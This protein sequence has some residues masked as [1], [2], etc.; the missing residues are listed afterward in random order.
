[1]RF[2][3]TTTALIALILMPV[4]SGCLYSRE[5]ARTQ[6]AVERENPTVSFDRK[7]TLSVG[8]TGIGLLSG[9]ASFTP[10]AEARDA[11]SYLR[12]LR[13]VK[14]GVYEIEGEDLSD[15]RIGTIPHLQGRGW[16]TL[17]NLRVPGEEAVS[18]MYRERHGDVRDLVVVGLDASHLV[19]LRFS[20]NITGML[21]EAVADNMQR[22]RDAL[23]LRA[24]P[25]FQPDDD[26]R[27]EG[28]I[29]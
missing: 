15:L 27:V 4:L 25:P 6:R 26:L 28:T 23:P 18:V 22:I 5:V 1:M 19:I 8:R 20:G 16:L 9:L 2:P 7:F 21:L 12:S 13:N 3:L 29:E 11:A 24:L 17:L 10:V 14:I